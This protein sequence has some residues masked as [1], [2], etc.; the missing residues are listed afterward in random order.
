MPNINALL[1][2]R[3]KI[4]AQIAQAQRREK[5]KAEIAALFEKHQLLDLT[6]EQIIRALKPQPQETAHAEQ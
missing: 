4:E 5:R 1:K 2:K 3:E 6:D